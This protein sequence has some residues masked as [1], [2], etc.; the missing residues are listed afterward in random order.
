MAKTHFFPM[1]PLDVWLQPSYPQ[2]SWLYGQESGGYDSQY[3]QTNY[4]LVMEPKKSGAKEFTFRV[5]YKAV[6]KSSTL[7]LA[8]KGLDEIPNQNGISQ[9]LT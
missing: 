4:L 6:G 2:K 9:C 1:M 7:L 8:I 5:F 3:I